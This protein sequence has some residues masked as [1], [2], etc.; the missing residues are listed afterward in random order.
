MAFQMGRR[1]GDLEEL[2]EKIAMPG[3]RGIQDQKGSADS[4]GVGRLPDACTFRNDITL[5]LKI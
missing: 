4:G 2:W 5:D 1:G 3:M